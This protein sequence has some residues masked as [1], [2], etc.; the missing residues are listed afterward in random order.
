MRGQRLR[1]AVENTLLTRNHQLFN[2]SRNAR[3][4]HGTLRGLGIGLHVLEQV[5]DV[6]VGEN[7]LGKT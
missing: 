4:S 3:V 7:S 2:L 1:R 5:V 6:G